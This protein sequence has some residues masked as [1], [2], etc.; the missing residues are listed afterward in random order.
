MQIRYA[1]YTESEELEEVFHADMPISR[2]FSVRYNISPGDIVPVVLSRHPGQY[3]IE[4]MKWGHPENTDDN[5]YEYYV[6][7]IK[8]K[9]DLKKIFQRQRCIIPANGFFLWQKMY[10]L[11]VPFYIRSIID[12]VI[13]FAGIYFND[14]NDAGSGS[15]SMIRIQANTLI[16]PIQEHMPAI[17]NSKQY[18]KW[19]DPVYSDMDQLVQ[20]LTP[21]STENMSVYRVSSGINDPDKNSKD[22]IQPVDA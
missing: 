7:E 9:P 11:E 17:L 2:P 13:G 5:G 18:E 16:Q 19:L 6:E 12:D 22:L 14:G 20:M 4:S 3:T 10:K 15:F 21:Y 8:N 1:L